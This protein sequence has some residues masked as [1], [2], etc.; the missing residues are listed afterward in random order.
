M[1][2]TRLNA[3]LFVLLL[4]L[5]GLNLA[6]Q[7][8]PTRRLPNLPWTN[9]DR[10]AAA[11]SFQPNEAFANGRSLQRPPAGT[12]RVGEAPLHSSD[13]AAGRELRS[14]VNPRNP[15]V[16][17]RGEELFS[18]YC[19][20]CHG[21]G[22]LGDGTV[23]KRGVPAPP[24]LLTSAAAARSDDEL[25]RIITN[26]RRTMPSYASQI[27]PDDRWRVIAFVRQAQQEALR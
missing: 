22:M 16:L 4:A 1:T 8:R 21:A 15:Q 6:V 23:T 9:M 19:V 18:T 26:G 20:V 14:T 13:T 27:E 11:T 7:P 24:S 2:T 12:V 10:T 3:G 5:A 17:A 25:Y